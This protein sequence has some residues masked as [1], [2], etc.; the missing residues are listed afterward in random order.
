M[1]PFPPRIYL[2]G[3]MG[4][5]KSTLGP[6]LANVLGYAF[7][8]LDEVIVRDA[9]QTIPQLFAEEGEAGFRMRERKALERTLQHEDLVVALGGGAFVQP[10]NQ[11]L[12]LQKG[13]VV[14]LQASFDTLVQRAIHS[15]GNRPL[16]NAPD[17]S[18]LPPDAIR[19]RVRELLAL[20]ET[21]YEKAH[22]C[23]PV[24]QGVM[25]ETVDRVAKA[26][27]AQEKKRGRRNS[28]RRYM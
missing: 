13:C 1:R 26:L 11:E 28:D 7:L 24:D 9:G 2:T 16:L 19:E 27:R 21:E 23:V 4:C 20:R 14:Y 15:K 25:A 12:L 18:R 6:I 10:K 5:G 17:G 8:D 22:L 3:F